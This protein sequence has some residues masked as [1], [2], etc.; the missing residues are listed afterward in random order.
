[1]LKKFSFFVFVTFFFLY[2][3]ST[4][5]NTPITRA[6]HNLTAHYNVY[7]NAKTALENAVKSINQKCRYNYFEILPVFPYECPQA[8]SIA[9]AKLNR[10]LK[11][12]AKTI[13]KHSIT[14][15]PEYK[16]YNRLSPAQIA[17]LKKKEYCK[18]ID[19]S[20]LLIGIANLYKGDISKSQRALHKILSDFKTENTRFDAQLWL[21]RSYI[22]QGRYLDAE[23][24]LKELMAD[25]RHPKRL[26]KDIL[27]TLADLYIHRQQYKQA[28]DYLSS[29]L[30]LIHNNQEKAKYTY[31][32]AQLYQRLNDNEQAGKL[33]KK[34]SKYN[35]P[36][37]LE[38]HAQLQLAT[39][40]G[41]KSNLKQIR[42]KLNKMLKD[43][44]NEE[45]RDKIYYALAQTYLKQKDTVNAIQYL[46]KSVALASDNLTKALTYQQIGE[47][48][49]GQKKYYQAGTY[50]DSTLNY[51]PKNYS[52]YK[53]IEQKS[54]NLIDL[55]QNYG[56]IHTQDSLL[57]LA[58]MPKNK[59][60]KIIDS[61]IEAKKR[62]QEVAYNS[63]PTF[64]PFDV[65]SQRYAAG[66]STTQNQGG[67][68]YFYNPMLVSRGEQLFRQRWGNRRLEDNWRRKNK[69]VITQAG[70]AENPAQK[71][72][73][74]KNLREFYLKQIPF[75]DSAKQVANAKIVDAMFNIALIYE[76]KLQDNQLAL[77]AYNDLI[78]KY[79][80]NKYLPDIYYHLFMIYKNQGQNDL[81]EIY[82][83]KIITQ[84]P[85]SRYARL[86]Q[87]SLSSSALRTKQ[88][89]AEKL[90]LNTIKLYDN[91]N[92]TSVID[93]A[94]Y[95]IK[96]YGETTVVPY[97][98]FLK[99]KAYAGLGNT[100][101]LKTILKEII[102]NYPSAEI[103]SVAQN[104]YKQLNQG[105]LNID[106]YKFSPNSPHV[107]VV[108]ADKKSN[109]NELKFN[110]FKWANEFSDTKKFEVQLLPLGKEKILVIRQFDNLDEARRFISYL[111]QHFPMQEKFLLFSVDNFKTFQKDKNLF[112]YQLFYSKYYNF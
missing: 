79:P 14:V 99:A 22:L 53:E 52:N 50:Y 38:F 35:P 68:W 94:N 67:K 100:D 29:A 41:N 45:Y 56:V 98:M 11:K 40:I 20:Y 90:L 88:I 32:L 55:A 60:L 1:M 6:Y 43:E 10:T 49:F 31:I 23:K 16:N 57:S 13:S 42:R 62:Q 46:K 18:W 86:L 66:M 47:L 37:E 81:A 21:A 89:K 109:I 65:E 103:T 59:V 97:F 72:E 75:S 26:D 84:F 63:N 44:K 8:K 24:T 30:K 87:N 27:I 110:L 76:N 70:T 7:F 34:V 48:Y 51:L 58:S 28:T 83:R 91:F 92:Y 12:A 102:D 54:K 25:P 15:K 17:F 39:T 77:Q 78:N 33:F 73:K 104:M 105:Q 85:K 2:S 112:K 5:K 64:D 3:C 80:D 9:S 108:F 107:M 19:D 71:Q 101:S 69:A 82:R 4:Q 106:I 61:I 36:Y 96:N 74:T 111:Q 95:G 93:S